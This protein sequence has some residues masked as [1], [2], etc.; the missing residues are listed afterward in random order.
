MLRFC[1][2]VG[3]GSAHLGA[4]DVPVV[5][6]LPF[7][8]VSRGPLIFALPLETEGMPHNYALECN[9]SSKKLGGT[10][11][12]PGAAFDWPLDAPVKVIVRAASV[13]WPSPWTLPPTPLPRPGAGHLRDV[14]LV[15]Y[16]CAKV[17]HVS[18]FPYLAP[19][20]QVTKTLV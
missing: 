16:G 17:H 4:G 6:D 11:Q 18:M 9:A 12:A 14:T 7:C 10:P 20:T 8:V 19:A 15:P 3:G 13:R 5:P 1:F 2:A